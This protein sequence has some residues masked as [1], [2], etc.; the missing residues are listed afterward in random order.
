MADHPES[1]S[2]SQPPAPASPRQER[3]ATGRHWT[4]DVDWTL[5]L[6]KAGAWLAVISFGGIFWAINGGF[7][8]MGLAI[9]A[10]SFNEAGDLFWASLAAITFTVPRPVAGLGATQPLIPWLGVV[11]ASILQVTIIIRRRRGQ[12]IPLWMWISGVILSVYDLTTTFYGLG[13][14]RWIQQAG[15]LV[16]AFLSA[17]LTFLLEL[18]VGMLVKKRHR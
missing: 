2:R 16:Q 9:I 14:L 11:A 17:V 8:V 1:A 12:P 5:W 15:V 13:T 4:N 7:S 6:A 18:T 10:T 3:R